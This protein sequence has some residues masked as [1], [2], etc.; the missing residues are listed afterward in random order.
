MIK[1]EV[2][3]VVTNIS[4]NQLQNIEKTFE[5]IE[6]N[7]ETLKQNMSSAQGFDQIAETIPPNLD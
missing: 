7:F 1:T 2:M 4:K 5:S 3:D 6:S